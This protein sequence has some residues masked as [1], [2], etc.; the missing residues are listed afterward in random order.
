MSRGS[1]GRARAMIAPFEVGLFLVLAA[2]NARKGRSQVRHC[3]A[4]GRWRAD[5]AADDGHEEG[6]GYLAGLVLGLDGWR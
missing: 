3:V 1:Y 2:V 4:L 6:A 5:T